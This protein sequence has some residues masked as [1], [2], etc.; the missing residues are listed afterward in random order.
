MKKF[1]IQIF[2]LCLIILGGFYLFE[3][4]SLYEQFLPQN[5]N[6]KQQQLKIGESIINIEVADTSGE[7]SKGLSGRESLASSSGMLFVYP[8]SK[9]YR[10]WMKDMKFN[11]DIIFID[12]GKVEDFIKDVSAPNPG[13]KDQDLPVYQPQKPIDMVLEVNSGFVDRQQIKIGDTVYLIN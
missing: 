2:L 10:F 13:Q 5:Q 8:E 12:N 7:R 11:I 9:Q 3:N 6:L 1:W 4:A